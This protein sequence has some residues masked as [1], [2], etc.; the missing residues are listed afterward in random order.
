MKIKCPLCDF[1]NE[2]GSKFCSNCNI[3]L[4]KQD[5]SED[6]PY[7]KKKN[8]E[9]DKVIDPWSEI[10]ASKDTNHSLTPKLPLSELTEEQKERIVFILNNYLSDFRSFEREIIALLLGGKWEWLEFDKWHQKFTELDYFPYMWS[11]VQFRPLEEIPEAVQTLDT[12]A[13][14]SL[15]A[16]RLL[17][18]NNAVNKANQVTR[19]VEDMGREVGMM[20]HETLKVI[21]EL[22]KFSLSKYPLAISEKLPILKVNDLKEICEEYSLPKTGK[23][24][25]IIKRISQNISE[26]ELRSLL[27]SEAQ[28]DSASIGFCLPLRARNYV[29]W[30]IAKIKLLTHT[31]EFSSYKFRNTEGY[32]QSGIVKKVVIIGLDGDP[33]PICAPQNKKIFNIN[34][35]NS[36][37]PFHPGCRCTT[38]PFFD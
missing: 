9:D 35:I 20:R 32:K 26:K 36:L 7:I 12:F 37:P 5:Y 18:G 6:N 31:L 28:R 27:P 24:V 15:D 13:S 25:E 4:I 8:K 14:L 33:C 3:P 2:E 17:V 16:R 23:K 34:D 19:A 38:A 21:E 1:E 11:S 30:N 10:T 22:K 29:D